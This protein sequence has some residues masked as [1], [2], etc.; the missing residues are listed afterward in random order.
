MSYKNFILFAVVM[1]FTAVACEDSYNDNVDASKTDYVTNDN[2]YPPTALDNWLSSNFTQPYNIQVKYRWDA[3]ELDLYKA[4]VPPSVNKV[5]DVMEVVKKV[6]IDTYTGIAGAN[7]IK[8]YCPKQFVLVGSA[9]YNFDGSFT[10]GTAEGGRKVVLYVINDFDRTS[11]YAVREMMHTIEHEFGHILHQNISY[12][13]E[14]KEITPGDYSSNWNITSLSTARSKGFITS[15][16]M[17]SADEDFVEMIAMMLVEGKEGYEDI[18]TCETDAVS[19]ELI[20]K[21]EKMVVD[22]FKESYD[23]DFYELQTLV[24]EAIHEIAPGNGGED[25]GAVFDSWG[26]DQEYTTVRFDLSVLNEPADFVTRYNYD[27]TIL[28]NTGYSLDYSFRLFFTSAEELT[29]RLYYYA[30]VDGMREYHEANMSFQAFP[31]GNESVTLSYLGADENGTY[32]IE[33][34]QATGLTSFFAN[35]P[36]KIDWSSTCSGERYVGFFPV[37]APEK[38]AFG[39]LSN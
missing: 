39:I 22:Y 19:Q 10:L 7:F 9:S 33:E 24:Q 27:N 25:P 14:F 5:Q 13:A 34:L 28:H 17:A 18:L 23:I 31:S 29:L 3:S 6:W 16:A 21:K 26:F 38:F 2:P 4:V 11:E 15:Y 12:P 8:Q 30:D 36:L 1:A 32:L 37:S 35:R 20:R